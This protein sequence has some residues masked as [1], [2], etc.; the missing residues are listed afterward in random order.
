MNRLS[1]YDFIVKVHAIAKIGLTYS[2]DAYALANYK[3]IQDLSKQMLESFL[4]IDFERP[5]YFKRD[6]YPTPNVSVRTIVF[7]DV[8]QVLLVKE[9][10]DGAY[11]LPGG[12]AD[13]Y[14]SPTQAA[15]KECR[16]EAG[17]NVEITRL[18]GVLNRTPIKGP[19]AIPEY[20]VVFEGKLLEP[21]FEHE[22]ETTDV[23][24]FDCDKLPNISR[25]VS[26]DEVLKMIDAARSGH[27]I[28]D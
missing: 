11:S 18:V 3:E 7:N 12:W 2:T 9:A 27:V 21:L 6:I 28:F 19:L 5:S 22:F 20:M 24:F 10:K 4:D 15:I 17:A 1:F 16:Q 23:G 8:G 25:K 13:L 26:R 14:E